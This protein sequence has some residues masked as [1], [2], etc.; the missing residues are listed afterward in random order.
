MQMPQLIGTGAPLGV[1]D[2]RPFGPLNI[3]RGTRQL[4]FNPLINH[5]FVLALV[6]GLRGRSGRY[7]LIGY[8][9]PGGLCIFRDYFTISM[10][11][12]WSSSTKFSRGQ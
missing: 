5:A 6:V 9:R 11:V 7:G 3:F 2:W 1:C 8:V 12:D 10:C 4:N